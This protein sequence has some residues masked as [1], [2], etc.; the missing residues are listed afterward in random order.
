VKKFF[1]K[2][3]SGWKQLSHYIGD[4]QARLLLTFFY[5][6]LALPFGLIGRFLI[7]PLKLRQK[8]T[9]SSWIK[10]ETVDQD[11]ATARNQF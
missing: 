1:G 7:D 4:F 2:L 6:T 11:I 3:W 5:F 10:R 9:S 8:K